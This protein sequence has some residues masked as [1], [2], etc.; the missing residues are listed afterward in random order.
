M[1]IYYLTCFCQVRS[2]RGLSGGILCLGEY[3]SQNQVVGRAG[4]LSESLREESTSRFQ[5]VGWIQFLVAVELWSP[6]SCWL[7][8]GNLSPIQRTLSK[9]FFHLRIE[10][11]HLCQVP[12]M[13]W[14]S[15]LP[16]VTSWKNHIQFFYQWYAVYFYILVSNLVSPSSWW[17]SLI[18]VAKEKVFD[19]VLISALLLLLLAVC[20][21]SLDSASALACP[22]FPFLLHLFKT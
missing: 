5:G 3:Q 11:V 18:C 1:H 4:F 16:C 7:S 10:K 2:M 14:I 9:G 13:L 6:F 17:L 21:G 19:L 15:A 12:L 22:V 20:S 8:V